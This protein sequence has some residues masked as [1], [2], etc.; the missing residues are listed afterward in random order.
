LRDAGVPEV[1]PDHRPITRSRNQTNS[2]AVCL[3]LLRSGR[4]VTGSLIGVLSVS[5]TLSS[6]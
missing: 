2:R 6:H 3:L 5:L 1:D 4:S